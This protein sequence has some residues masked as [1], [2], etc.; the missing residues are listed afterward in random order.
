MQYDIDFDTNTRL[1]K[2]DGQ[3]TVTAGDNESDVLHFTFIDPDR[4]LDGY[5]A[6]C[7]FDSTV[8][9]ELVDNCVTI[10]KSVMIGVKLRLQLM[11]C[12]DS[13][14]FY[15]LNILTVKLNK[16]ISR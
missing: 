1:M 16:V 11:F 6:Y 12:K 14:R 10:P 15:S 7:I 3:M 2:Y 8:K 9:R 5:D 13:M 4:L